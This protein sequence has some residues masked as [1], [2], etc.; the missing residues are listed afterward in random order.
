MLLANILVQNI[1]NLRKKSTSTFLAPIGINP[2]HV[3]EEGHLNGLFYVCD[4]P[5]L[6]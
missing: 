4:L 1:F 2:I 3:G 5:N 6:A